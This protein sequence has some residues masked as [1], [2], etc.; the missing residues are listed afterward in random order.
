MKKLVNLNDLMVEELRELYDAEVQVLD[1]MTRLMT[2]PTHPRLS[3]MMQHYIDLNEEQQMRIRQVFE[4]LFVQ[5]RGEKS[6][7]MT[8]MIKK[9]DELTLRC[10]DAETLDALIVVN[11]QHMIHYKIA[12]YGAICTYLKHLELFEEADIMHQS[13][14]VEKNIDRQ[15][16]MIADSFIDREAIA[17][18]Y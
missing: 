2:Y 13:L 1:A 11:L 15:L 5:K 6:A 4:N 14:E 3:T 8:T 16:A 10:E 7:S 9:L 12:S 18:T 17:P